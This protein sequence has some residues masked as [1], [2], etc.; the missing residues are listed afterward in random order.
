M[1][2]KGG[3]STVPACPK[4]E[5]LAAKTEEEEEEEKF[6]ESLNTFFMEFHKHIFN[7]V[8]FRLA[9]LEIRKDLS[10]VPKGPF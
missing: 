3:D 8:L 2:D 10:D 4:D 5:L 9:A 7:P 6:Q 1:A